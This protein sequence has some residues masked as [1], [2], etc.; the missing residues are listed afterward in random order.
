MSEVKT[1]ASPIEK[2]E[3]LIKN[4]EDTTVEKAEVEEVVTEEGVAT[5]PKAN[6]AC[7]PVEGPDSDGECS[8]FYDA[9]AGEIQEEG[10]SNDDKEEPLPAANPETITHRSRNKENDDRSGLTGVENKKTEHKQEQTS[11]TKMSPWSH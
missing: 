9:V 2:A 6:D 4:E 10:E 1:E 5:D 8:P 3:D 7:I 11:A